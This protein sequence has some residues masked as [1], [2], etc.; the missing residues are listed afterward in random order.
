MIAR[1]RANDNPGDWIDAGS[2]APNWKLRVKVGDML[3][4]RANT[5]SP[6]ISKK[7]TGHPQCYSLQA[8]ILQQIIIIT[9]DES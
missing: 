7:S 2:K 8:P 6:K 1:A 3:S 4:D 5:F 9:A